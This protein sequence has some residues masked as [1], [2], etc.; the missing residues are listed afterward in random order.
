M[1]ANYFRGRSDVLLED[2]WVGDRGFKLI[3]SRTELKCKRTGSMCM[4]FQVCDKNM[5][6]FV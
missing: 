5:H 4:Q 2:G 3:T 1:R 6:I